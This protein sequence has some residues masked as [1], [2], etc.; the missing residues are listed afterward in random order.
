MGSPE[1]DHVDVGFHVSQRL[2][3]DRDRRPAIS[4]DHL[5]RPD[6]MGIFSG[7]GFRRGQQRDHQRGIDQKDLFPARSISADGDG[8]QTGGTDHQLC[9]I[10]GHDGLLPNHPQHPCLM[11]ASLYPLHHG[12]GPHYQFFRRRD[13]R[14]LPRH[15][16]GHTHRAIAVDVRLAGNLSVKPGAKKTSGR[17]S[18]RRVVG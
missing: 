11:A 3:R 2:C 17:T 12:R 1:T 10:G 5:C 8:Y 14:V 4:A 6:S 7:I 13:E 9:H 15:R 16:P 18:R